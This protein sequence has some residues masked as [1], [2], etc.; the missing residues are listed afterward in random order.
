[1][2]EADNKSNL[3]ETASRCERTRRKNDKTSTCSDYIHRR[4]RFSK[5][6]RRGGK[7]VFVN[8]NTNF[9]VRLTVTLEDLQYSRLEFNE[10]IYRFIW[11]RFV[12]LL[13][14]TCKYV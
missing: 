7:D 14:G 4:T 2:A 11:Q 3:N 10:K 1:M 6:N 13:S 9:K 8:N 12:I 5:F